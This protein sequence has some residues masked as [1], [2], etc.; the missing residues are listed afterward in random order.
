MESKKRWNS[1]SNEKQYLHEVRVRQLAIEDVRKQ[2]EDHFGSKRDV[3]EKI[4]GA[5][6]LGEKEI[7]NRIKLLK[8]ANKASWSAVEK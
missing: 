5:I 8:M 6:R 4:E 3:P 2:L 7:D 1:L